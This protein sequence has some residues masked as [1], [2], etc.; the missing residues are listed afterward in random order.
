M[1]GKKGFMSSKQLFAM[2]CVVGLGLAVLLVSG[3]ISADLGNMR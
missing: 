3:C 1:S 2:A